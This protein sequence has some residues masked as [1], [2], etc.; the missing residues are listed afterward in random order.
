MMETFNPMISS[1]A[2][3]QGTENENKI[4]SLWHEVL[5]SMFLKALVYHVDLLYLPMYWIKNYIYK[6]V[7]IVINK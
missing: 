2:A 7:L 1:R 6:A 5:S 4:C 3:S